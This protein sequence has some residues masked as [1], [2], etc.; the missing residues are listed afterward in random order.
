MISLCKITHAEDDLR[1]IQRR[2]LGCRFKAEAGIRTRD[3]GIFALK[4]GFW[5]G[6][7]RLA[8]EMGSSDTTVFD[9]GSGPSFPRSFGEGYSVAP[10]RIHVVVGL[11]GKLRAA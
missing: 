10:V 4:G 8:K 2:E 1:R 6:E 5:A 9:L 7:R 11:W 3:N